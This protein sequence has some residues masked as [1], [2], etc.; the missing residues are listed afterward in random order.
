MHFRSLSK[1]ITLSPFQLALAFDSPLFRDVNSAAGVQ[2]L[3]DQVGHVKLRYGAIERQDS[4]CAGGKEPQQLEREILGR[5]GIAQ[6]E[7]VMPPRKG[8]RF[9]S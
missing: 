2:G 8:A 4:D 3:V 9:A 7:K 1:P 6:I 5:L